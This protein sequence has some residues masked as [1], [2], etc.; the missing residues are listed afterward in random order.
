MIALSMPVAAVHEDK[1]V[2]HLVIHVDDNDPAKFNLALNNALNVTQHYNGVG[3]E[4]E[5]ELQAAGS[6]H[7]ADRQLS[8]APVSRAGCCSA[9]GPA[10]PPTAR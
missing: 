1:K 9:F 4:V 10:L 7:V 5:V 3:E 6:S 8:Q 2:H